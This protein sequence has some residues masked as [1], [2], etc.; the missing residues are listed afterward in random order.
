M[1]LLETFKVIYLLGAGAS[2][3][4]KLPDIRTLTN[5]F[6]EESKRHFESNEIGNKISIL[7][8][9]TNSHYPERQDLESFM[10]L[11]KRLQYGDD[12]Q[13]FLYKYGQLKNIDHSDIITINKFAQDF[14]RA[15]LEDINK[16]SADYL[17][18]FQGLINDGSIEIFSLNYD[19]VIDLFCENFNIGYS[20]GF[21]PFWDPSSFDISN[22]IVKIFKLHG[23]L[24]WF[25]STSGKIVKIPVKGLK[26]DKVKYIS[27]DLLDEMMIYPTLQ[28]E[29]Y[30]EIYAWLS[31]KFVSTLN[32]SNLLV[33]IGYSF[34]DEDITSNIQQ[35]LEYNED[36]WT[37]IVSPNAQTHKD[38]LADNHDIFLRS[39]I[40]PINM[41]IQDVLVRGNLYEF[42]RILKNNILKEREYFKRQYQVRA[43]L[44][45]WRK[46]IASYISINHTERNE[47]IEKTLKLHH[48]TLDID[49]VI[50]DGKNMN[51]TLWPY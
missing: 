40:I 41:Q 34:R 25:K 28:K 33:V 27:D 2:L 24:Y 39:R 43:V 3:P 47:L 21:T 44:S 30:S 32:Q 8:E 49:L 23:S 5:D 17:S 14:I 50:R 18:P 15:K 20:D 13:L 1:E 7:K 42:I 35:A 48:P 29:K 26:L 11:T 38:K 45:D 6:F 46:L 4:A 12:Y 51:H 31:N 16:A 37:I 10:T 22:N 19:G 9:V 36:L